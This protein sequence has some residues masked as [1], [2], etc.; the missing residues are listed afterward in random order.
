M[1]HPRRPGHAGRPGPA[2]QPGPA[3]RPAGADSVGDALEV[4]LDAIHR[5]RSRPEARRAVLGPGGE[6]LSVTDRWL[7]SRLDEAGP[8]RMSALARWQEVEPSTM[9]AQVRRLEGR[10]WII[11]Q[12]DP[13]DRRVVMV[14]LQPAGQQVIR[15]ANKVARETANDLVAH[16]SEH[17]RRELTR[18]LVRLA[19]ELDRLPVSA[20]PAA[21]DR[22]R[23]GSNP[24]RP[25]APATAPPRGGSSP[26]P[27]GPG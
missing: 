26:G 5:A 3:E 24:G 12:P 20:P 10:G 11:R 13:T 25:G 23:G 19:G 27:D 6:S 8:L 17:D 7:L 2:K 4:A 1:G 14:A 22:R 9:T 21:A 16:W 15:H 18:L